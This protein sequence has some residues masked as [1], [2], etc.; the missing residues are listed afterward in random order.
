VDPETGREEG[1][2]LYN[3]TVLT[4][5]AVTLEARRCAARNVTWAARAPNPKLDT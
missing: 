1:T 4:T 3:V 2:V 5:P